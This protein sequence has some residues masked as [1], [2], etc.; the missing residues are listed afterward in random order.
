MICK[1]CYRVGGNSVYTFMLEVIFVFEINGV[2]VFLC[3]YNTLII[4]YV[5]LEVNLM[6]LM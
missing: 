3:N 4:M 1:T 6:L 5:Y 2:I